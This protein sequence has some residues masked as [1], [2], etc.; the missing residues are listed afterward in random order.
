MK[1]IE[2]YNSEFIAK[3]FYLWY[4]ISENE[5]KLN[6]RNVICMTTVSIRLD[7]QDKI[8]LEEMCADMGMNIS[9]FYM[10]Y[11]KKVLRDRKIPFTIEAPIEP[12]YSVANMEQIRKADAQVKAG[13][14]VTRSLEEL[15]TMANE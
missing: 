13:K 7:D 15:E 1:Q 3:S 6:E 12:F 5:M 8:A 9:T 10:L 4:F 14:V 2:T 11:T